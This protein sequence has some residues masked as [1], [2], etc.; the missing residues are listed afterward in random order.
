MS[1]LEV[2]RILFRGEIDLGPDRHQQ[3]QH[4]LQREHRR[5]DT[6]ERGR[7]GP[8]VSPGRDRVGHK[9]QLESTWYA[10]G[11]VLRFRD[12]RC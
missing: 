12:F 2:P 9:G 6:S 5:S 8:G 11:G 7:Q 1:V 10:P 4:L 3:L